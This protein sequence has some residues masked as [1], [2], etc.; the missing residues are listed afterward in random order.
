LW[1]PSGY[2]GLKWAKSVFKDKPPFQVANIHLLFDVL[3]IRLAGFN[4][5][6]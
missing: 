2:Q 6:D 3:L 4:R 5:T 1:S